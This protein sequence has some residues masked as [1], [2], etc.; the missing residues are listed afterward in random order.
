MAGDTARQVIWAVET[1]IGRK[2]VT[3]I[4]QEIAVRKYCNRE[5]MKTTGPLPQ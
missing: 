4:T 1:E 2:R 5:M 3:K